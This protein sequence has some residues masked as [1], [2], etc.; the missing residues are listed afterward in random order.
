MPKLT[1]AYNRRKP[2]EFCDGSSSKTARRRLDGTQG[3]GYNSQGA[4]LLS[5]RGGHQP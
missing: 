3:R 2:A 4:A 1:P 5:T